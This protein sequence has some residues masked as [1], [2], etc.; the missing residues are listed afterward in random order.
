MA[1][2][3][4]KN[5]M[6]AERVLSHNFHNNVNPS[7]KQSLYINAVMNSASK[8]TIYSEQDQSPIKM[9]FS[10]QRARKNTHAG[11]SNKKASNQISRNTSK[12]NTPDI[13]H[14]AKSNESEYSSK[15]FNEPMLSSAKKV[16]TK[17]STVV[18]RS[19]TVAAS[20]AEKE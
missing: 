15:K 8:K 10:A 18:T 16:S 19:I 9:N 5:T 12:Q 14:E 20:P 4:L 6:K 17:S 7:S 3:S 11:T 13:K 2:E 1:A